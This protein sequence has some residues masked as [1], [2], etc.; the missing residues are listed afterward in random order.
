MDTG[1]RSR[2]RTREGLLGLDLASPTLRAETIAFRSL[3]GRPKLQVAE[4]YGRFGDQ[5]PSHRRVCSWES[6]MDSRLDVR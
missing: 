6:S 1:F 4:S 3:D 5:T 2:L